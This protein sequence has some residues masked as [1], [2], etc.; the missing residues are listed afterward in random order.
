MNTG[1][2]TVVFPTEEEALLVRPALDGKFVGRRWLN[3]MSGEAARGALLACGHGHAAAAQGQ[4][5][6]GMAA[7]RVGVRRGRS[8]SPKRQRMRPG[9]RSGVGSDLSGEGATPGD[10]MLSCGPRQAVRSWPVPG[11][12]PAL[13][14][15]IRLRS[16]MLVAT[17]A[18]RWEPVF[19][20]GLRVLR[21]GS[22]AAT[23]AVSWCVRDT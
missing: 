2:A 15:A 13:V 8:P 5:L 21:R 14:A 19:L 20:V 16:A 10:G 1:L 7:P 4:G 12:A 9:R 18:P 3:V 11:A 23:L 22:A 6:R 17:V